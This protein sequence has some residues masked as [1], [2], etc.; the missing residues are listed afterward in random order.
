VGDQ[1]SAKAST[2][3]EKH[4]HTSMPRAGFEPVIPM[5]ERPKTVLALDRRFIVHSF[6]NEIWICTGISRH[7]D[8]NEACL[9]HAHSSPSPEVVK[10]A[11][12]L[13]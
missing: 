5:F 6:R 3:T 7:G 2:Y 9:C 12:V 8:D 11:Q 13:L 10:R 1:S 4:R